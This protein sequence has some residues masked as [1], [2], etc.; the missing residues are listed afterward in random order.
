MGQE[1]NFQKSM[2][3][4]HVPGYEIALCTAGDGSSVNDEHISYL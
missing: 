3:Q 2:N 4:R 1:I